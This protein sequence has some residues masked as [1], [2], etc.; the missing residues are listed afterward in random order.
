[1]PKPHPP[2]K[3]ALPYFK[4]D[5]EAFSALH[6]PAWTRHDITRTIETIWAGDVTVRNHYSTRIGRHRLSGLPG[7][8]LIPAHPYVQADVASA[9]A[10]H[11]VPWQR[12]GAGLPIPPV[13]MVP[14]PAPLPPPPP[15]RPINQYPF[16]FWPAEPWH[17]EPDDTMLGKSAQEVD[18]DPESINRFMKG[19]L[20]RWPIN[21]DEDPRWLGAK[22]LA[23]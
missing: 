17:P 10:T 21:N 22:F 16:D 9:Q 8:N 19:L 2:Y 6:R 13:I 12:D 7:Q 3:T 1:M 23:A 14:Q 5:T 11:V 4:R 18:Q 20:N 15:P